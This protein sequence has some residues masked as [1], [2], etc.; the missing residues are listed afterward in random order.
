MPLQPMPFRS[1]PHR[2]LVLASTVAAAGLLLT[3]AG[4][5][6]VAP[7]GPAPQPRQLGT[8]IVLK[9]IRVQPPAPAGG[10]PVGFSAVSAPGSSATMCGQPIGAPFKITTAAISPL[11]TMSSALGSSTPAPTQYFFVVALPAASAGGLTAVTTTAFD[12]HGNLD[13][14]VAGRTWLLPQ[15]L[16]PLTRGQFQIT[17]PSKAQA[18][19]LQ[20][21]LTGPG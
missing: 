6:R 8:P 10:C 16:A 11:G 18:L 17:L 14:S 2:L 19:H 3:L 4:C 20:R 12:H 21:V 7:L 15:V 5:G 13:V 9:A 1:L